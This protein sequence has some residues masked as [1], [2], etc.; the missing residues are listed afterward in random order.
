MPTHYPII[1]NCNYE[2]SEDTAI[3]EIRIAIDRVLT[4]DQDLL[5]AMEALE[6]TLSEY[7]CDESVD[8]KEA[9][10]DAE[11]DVLAAWTDEIQAEVESERKSR[12][13]D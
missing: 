11:R 12:Y 10:A 4:T 7:A 9:C 2:S 1:A 6:N 13:V 5:D 8:A 3:H